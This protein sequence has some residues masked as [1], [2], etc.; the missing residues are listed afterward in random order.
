MQNINSNAG[1]ALQAENTEASTL[2]ISIL[3]G[4]SEYC[5]AHGWR[6]TGSL[7]QIVQYKFN[8][9]K[10]GKGFYEWQK[11]NQHTHTHWFGCE[12]LYPSEISCV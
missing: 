4:S 9:T 3:S 2:L 1:E 8:V 6:K 5:N 11:F 10:Q 7:N 12:I